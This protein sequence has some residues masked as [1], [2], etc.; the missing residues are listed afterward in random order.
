[1]AHLRNSDLALV[2]SATFDEGER[3]AQ[4][5]SAAHSRNRALGLAARLLLTAR[6]KAHT[7]Y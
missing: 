7:F 1:M 2:V 4:I 3:S 6:G 5:R